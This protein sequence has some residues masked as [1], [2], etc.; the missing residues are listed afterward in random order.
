MKKL[1]TS[2]LIVSF[3][4]LSDIASASVVIQNQSK[5][6]VTINVMGCDK[7][8]LCW[9]DEYQLGTSRSTNKVNI[10]LNENGTLKIVD[11]EEFDRSGK[12]VAKLLNTCKMPSATKRIFLSDNGSPNITCRYE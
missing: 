8:D 11:A 5:L 3:T 1:A 12:V 10:K 6:P 9:G 7:P 2:L 4:F